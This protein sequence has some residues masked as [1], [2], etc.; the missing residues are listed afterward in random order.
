M[1]GHVGGTQ[2]YERRGIRTLK[3]SRLRS[4]T[5]QDFGKVKEGCMMSNSWKLRVLLRGLWPGLFVSLIIC[6]DVSGVL[7]ATPRVAEE[8]RQSSV[9]D[10]SESAANKSKEHVDCPACRARRCKSHGIGDICL[11]CYN[12]CKEAIR[13]RRYGVCEQAAREF[14]GLLH[15]VIEG[16]RPAGISESEWQRHRELAPI[17]YR[18]AIASC[19]F[20]AGRYQEALKEY[21]RL[22]KEV[23]LCR[24]RCTEKE[25]RGSTKVDF[26]A[27]IFLPLQ[28]AK[29]CVEL[30]EYDKAR[31]YLQSASDHLPSGKFSTNMCRTCISLDVCK[32][33]ASEVTQLLTAMALN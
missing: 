33:A 29:C 28:Q 7:A 16:P 24:D 10:L 21:Q 6:G 4:G 27:K 26:F 8:D 22:E 11:D 12:H 1:C 32:S 31:K 15:E 25:G 19:Y 13:H 14:R 9:A 30:S 17:I 20:E 2:R 18:S 23:I 3:R 5:D